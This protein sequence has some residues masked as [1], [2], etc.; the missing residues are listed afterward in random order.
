MIPTLAASY[1]KFLQKN[2]ASHQENSK[3]QYDS[4]NP[5]KT[6]LPAMLNNSPTKSQK[7]LQRNFR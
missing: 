3:E 4:Y 1:T 5:N 2:G 6:Y 7:Q